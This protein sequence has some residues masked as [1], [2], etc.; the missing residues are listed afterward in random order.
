MSYTIQ[1]FKDEVEKNGGYESIVGL[2]FNNSNV[3]LF[4]DGPFDPEVNLDEELEVIVTYDEDIAGRKYRLTRKLVYLEGM[5]TILDPSH[6]HLI[7]PR[8]LR[9]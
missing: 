3:T 9:Y 6:R 7:D 8:S 4:I 1:E 2:Y 5:A